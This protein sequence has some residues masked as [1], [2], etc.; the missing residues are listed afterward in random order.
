MGNNPYGAFKT[1]KAAETTAGVILDYPELGCRVR[2]ARAGGANREY[3]KQIN[4]RLEP[5]RDRKGRIKNLDDDKAREI[6]AEIYADT[7]VLGWE[8]LD[9]DKYV[10]GI[11]DPET[12]E[13]KPYERSMVIKVFLAVPDFFHDVQEQADDI[14]LFRAEN[15]E[16]KGKNS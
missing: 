12:G 5:Y 1:D 14:A 9:G 4:S 13:T 8:V 15:L 16:A 6:M 3:G 7:I 2:I 10:S 11:K